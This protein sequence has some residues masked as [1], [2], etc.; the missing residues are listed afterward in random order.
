MFTNLTTRRNSS[1][2]FSRTSRLRAP[3]LLP[4]ARIPITPIVQQTLVV[5]AA[6]TT[7]VKD[8][9][10]KRRETIFGPD[11]G[12]DEE[13]GWVEG[14]EGAKVGVETVKGWVE[15]AKN[16]EVSTWPS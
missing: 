7:E 16:E 1:G 3:S 10:V 9:K 15:K 6:R 4:S 11:V 14:S 12:E 5:D 2:P 8:E 13:P